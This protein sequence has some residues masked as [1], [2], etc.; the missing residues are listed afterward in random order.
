MGEIANEMLFYGGI[1][2]LIMTIIAA[3]VFVCVSKISKLRLT[4]QL[5]AEYGENEHE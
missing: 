4:T 1:G 5:N 2:I 3:I